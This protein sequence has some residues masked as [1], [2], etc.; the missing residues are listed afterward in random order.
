MA[1]SYPVLDFVSYPYLIKLCLYPWQRMSHFI[2]HW[3]ACSDKKERCV[4]SMED[5]I[6]TYCYM[7]WKI[8]ANRLTSVS[9][10]LLPQ[11]E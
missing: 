5:R 1:V 11:L 8:K 6:Y 9:A 3:R 2:C 10:V 4:V 7:V